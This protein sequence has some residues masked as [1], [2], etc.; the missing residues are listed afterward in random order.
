MEN[1]LVQRQEI[2]R[3]EKELERKRREDEEAEVLEDEAVQERAVRQFEL[4]QMGLSVSKPGSLANVAARENGK[5]V[6]VTEEKKG[7][8]RK[9]EL[10]EDEL[11]EIARADR[12]KAKK[13][14]TEEKVWKKSLNRVA[15][16]IVVGCI[17]EG[18]FE[19]L[20]PFSDTVN[21]TIRH[22]H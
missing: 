16:L 22:R 13:A 10:D 12:E 19:F 9:F 14:L 11:I 2:K 6:I 8:K 1:L 15:M 17:E 5:V 7:E 18:G 4:V 20:G 21:R 3:F